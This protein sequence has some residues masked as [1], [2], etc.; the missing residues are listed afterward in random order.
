VTGA[1]G[2]ATQ[3][4]NSAN[5]TFASKFEPVILLPLGKKWLFET[6]Y[7]MELPVQRQDS[8]LGPAVFSH[9]FEYLQMSYFAT[10]N[11]IVTGGNFVT[12]FGIYKERLDPQWVRN[13]LDE[14]LVFPINDNSSIGAMVR[15][16]AY[17]SPGVKLNVAGYYSG[18]EGNAQIA[19]EKQSGGRASVFLTG[20]RIEVGASYSRKMG[21]DRFNVAGAD[22][23]W[24]VRRTPLDI[25]GEYVH[26]DILGQGYWLEGAWRLSKVTGSSFVHR[27][28]IVGRVEQY[29]APAAKQDIDEDLPSLDT[30]RF[31][32]GFNYWPSDSVKFAFAYARQTD[33]SESRG[34]WT[35]GMV[36]RFTWAK[37]E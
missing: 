37:G 4:Q 36:Y 18:S 32:A 2:V 29:R 33:S 21:D 9:S 35:V 3:I 34:V 19:G 31:T 16:S 20:P 5:L 28:Q 27:S 22:F 30:K 24:N 14:P 15:S 17:L 13:L 6:E 1:F 23:V 8:S 12:P 7:S 26:A 10:S 11:L 25:R